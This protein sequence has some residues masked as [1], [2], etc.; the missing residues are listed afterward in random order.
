MG[1]VPEVAG[2]AQLS[3]AGDRTTVG[4]DQRLAALGGND[5]QGHRQV[6]S[7]LVDPHP[8]HHIDENVS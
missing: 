4:P 8:T 2:K 5:S 3:E 6:R 1:D 7:G